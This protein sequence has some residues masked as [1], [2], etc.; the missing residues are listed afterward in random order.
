M[1]LSKA[2]KV[3]IIAIA[4]VVLLIGGAVF[5]GVWWLRSHGGMEGLA[6]EMDDAMGEGR[7]YAR[8]GHPQAECLAGGIEALGDCWG[9]SC[10]TRGQLWVRGCL[11][12][13]APSPGL[14]DEVPSPLRV[15]QVASW[16]M[17]TCN[18]LGKQGNQTCVQVAAALPQWC[19][20]QPD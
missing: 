11:D 18:G 16:Q 1:A 13:A 19:E 2:A 14:C 12:A 5:A 9:I 10:V 15:M 3:T 17:D 8:A 4:A 7:S 6:Q 20:E